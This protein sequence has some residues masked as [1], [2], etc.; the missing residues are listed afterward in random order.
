MV[1][2]PALATDH[3]V[4]HRAT[5]APPLVGQLPEPL[6]QFA[7]AIGTW[8]APQAASGE[9]NPPAGATLRQTMRGPIISAT[10]SRFT[11]GR[12]RFLPACP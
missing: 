1:H 4:E 10:I 8:R 9:R 12:S 6:A 2:A 3:P 7:I 11:A 5:P